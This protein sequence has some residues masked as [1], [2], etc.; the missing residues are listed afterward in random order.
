MQLDID[1][2]G[3]Q[4]QTKRSDASNLS[5]QFAIKM[6]GVYDLQLAEVAVR[7]CCNEPS[8]DCS[9]SCLLCLMMMCKSLVRYHDQPC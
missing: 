7:D 1:P 4:M 9:E 2:D 5:R 3:F 6:R 8:T